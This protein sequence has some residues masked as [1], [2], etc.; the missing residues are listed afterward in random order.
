MI[1]KKYEASIICYNPHRSYSVTIQDG[2]RSFRNGRTTSVYLYR[3]DGKVQCQKIKGYHKPWNDTVQVY[4]NGLN[5]FNYITLN[6][7]TD[8]LSNPPSTINPSSSPVYERQPLIEGTSA[9]ESLPDDNTAVAQSPA[10]MQPTEASELLTGDNYVVN[11][12]IPTKMNNHTPTR[13]PKSSCTSPV[14]KVHANPLT[15]PM[16]E[17]ILQYKSKDIY[18][19]PGESGSDAD[20]VLYHSEGIWEQPMTCGDYNSLLQVTR[21]HVPGKKGS[22]VVQLKWKKNSTGRNHVADTLTSTIVKNNMFA[23]HLTHLFPKWAEVISA[24]KV[25]NELKKLGVSRSSN[26]FVAYSN[27]MC[28][29]HHLARRQDSEVAICVQLRLWWG[30]HWRTYWSLLTMTQKLPSLYAPRFLIIVCTKN[31]M[32]QTPA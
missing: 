23:H 11:Y 19:L 14:Q 1:A 8:C 18:V 31:I 6:E 2:S 5:H 29:H 28:N 20:L 7:D 21:V 15:T 24:H 32:N 17:D 10:K 9:S 12:H 26:G 27:G 25:G 30:L 16:R 3:P 4:Y 13:M 22:T